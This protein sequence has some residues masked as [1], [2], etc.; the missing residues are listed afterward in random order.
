MKKKCL[1]LILCTLCVF[2]GC[3]KEEGKE[4]AQNETILTVEQNDYAGGYHRAT[5]LI[6]DVKNVLTDLENHNNEIKNKNPSDYWSEDEFYHLDFYPFEHE[7]LEYINLLNE[8][9]DFSA[10]QTY[11]SSL[12]QSNGYSS[13]SVMRKD[14][15]KYAVSYRGDFTNEYNWKKE[16]GY[17][18][19]D[20]I[21]DPHTNSLQVK[22]LFN[23]NNVKYEDFIYEFAEISKGIYA[24]QDDTDRLYAIYDENG[25]IKEF[26]YSRLAEK[27]LEEIENTEETKNDFDYMFGSSN[28]SSD[29]KNEILTTD[30]KNTEE[31]DSIFNN[32]NKCS[33]NW[34]FEKDNLKTIITYKDETLYVKTINELI[35]EN[36]EFTYKYTTTVNEGHAETKEAELTTIEEEKDLVE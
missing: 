31:A 2:T 14:K 7:S 10:L 36:I 22:S 23:F 11:I 6:N 29:N 28:G 8:V 35:G 24:L 30:W 18:N 4:P 32:L 34:V 16:Y 25:E 20:C 15:D 9:D 19:M 21:Y 13:I 33:A 3:G 27:E 5:M 12:I 1:A 26:Y 17:R